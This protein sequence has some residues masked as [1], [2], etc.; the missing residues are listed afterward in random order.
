MILAAIQ[1]G[2]LPWL[3]YLEQMDVVDI[4][5][6]LDDV[7]YTRQD[8]RNR[9]RLLN[10]AGEAE[11]LTVP[12]RANSDRHLIKDVF[13]ADDASWSRKI[14]NKLKAWYAR[15]PYAEHYLPRVNDILGRKRERL[16]DLNYDLMDMLIDAYG[17]STLAVRASDAAISATDKNQRLIDLCRHHGA[18]ILYDG[19]AAAN[20]ID[21]KRFAAAGI[22]VI[23]QNYQPQSYAQGAH[24]FVSHLSSLDALLWCGEGARKVL[25]GSPLPDALSSLG[26]SA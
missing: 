25:R 7:K 8:W 24:P 2:F 14:T 13:I 17:I 5:V 11:Y 1:P 10:A 12:V 9:N 4:F 19:A 23:F 21:L 3:G 6:Y 20:F 26:I 16:V 15:A 22:A 18:D